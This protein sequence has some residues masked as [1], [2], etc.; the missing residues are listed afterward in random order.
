Y[1][2]R[3][4][5][6]WGNEDVPSPRRR[7]D[8][9]R[10]PCRGRSRGGTGRETR[11]CDFDAEARRRGDK[12]GEAAQSKRGRARRQRRMVASGSERTGFRRENQEKIGGSRMRALARMERGG[13]G[14]QGHVAPRGCRGVPGGGVRGAESAVY[15]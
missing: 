3:G 6:G 4:R 11:E 15:D 14:D 1:P 7:R 5:R 12:R 2:R 8:K 13:S 9:R 10:V